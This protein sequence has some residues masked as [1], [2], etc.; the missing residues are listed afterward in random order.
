LTHEQNLALIPLRWDL[1]DATPNVTFDSLPSRF[2]SLDDPNILFLLVDGPQSETASPFSLLKM[3]LDLCS[4]LFIPCPVA[5][6][7]NHPLA[8]YPG[9]TDSEFWWI[10][11]PDRSHANR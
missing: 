6:S 10:C 7:F 8:F 1:V 4:I 3:A 2:H 9:T 11:I 5:F